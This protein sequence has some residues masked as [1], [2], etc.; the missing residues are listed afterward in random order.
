MEKY[1]IFPIDEPPRFIERSFMN[2]V[3]HLIHGEPSQGGS[4]YRMLLPLAWRSGDADEANHTDT[5][6]WIKSA[7]AQDPQIDKKRR[8]YFTRETSSL[9]LDK[10]LWIEPENQ[11]GWPLKIMVSNTVDKTKTEV[12]ISAPSLVLFEA[13][14][15]RKNEKDSPLHVAFLIID[16]SFPVGVSIDRFLTISEVFRYW[17]EPFEGLYE[18]RKMMIQE[19]EDKTS[20]HYAKIWQPAFAL[21]K[22]VAF[23][24][25]HFHL[26]TPDDDSFPL[27]SFYADNRAFVCSFCRFNKNSAR[28]LA[29]KGC[30][31]NAIAHSINPDWT[32]HANIMAPWIKLLNVDH[33]NPAVAFESTAFEAEWAKSRTYLRWAHCGTLHGFTTHSYA[34]LYTNDTNEDWNKKMLGDFRTH[35][36]DLTLYSFYLRQ[37]LMRFNA[38]LFH[39]TIS[40][41]C[42]QMNE[43]KSQEIRQEYGQLREQYLIFENLY[44]FPLLTTQQQPL[45]MYA[46]QQRELDVQILY[47]EMSLQI[48]NS[49]EFFASKI[50]EK[51]AASLEKINYLV[52]LSTV[53]SV[54]SAVAALADLTDNIAC[55]ALIGLLL[56][57]ILTCAAYNTKNFKNDI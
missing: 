13:L 53:L 57:M 22:N 29:G 44:R 55:T 27:K 6:T 20:S 17:E 26:A 7:V 24:N 12:M 42:N 34:W 5:Q 8:N 54:I 11:L 32:S 40:L 3:E 31:K 45:E 33:L 30:L 41:N 46:I 38:K 48:Q 50:S 47:E 23:G 19:S 56:G 21:V 43:K 18:E 14:A 39:I 25:R 15:D 52:I 51:Q 2:V 4:H 49:D 35:Y 1:Q 37:V 9:L 16:V 10:A 28:E 36:T